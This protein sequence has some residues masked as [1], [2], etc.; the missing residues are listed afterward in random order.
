ML[1]I[2]R[3]ILPASLAQEINLEYPHSSHD[4]QGKF[5]SLA[6]TGSENGTWIARPGERGGTGFRERTRTFGGTLEFDEEFLHPVVHHLHLVIAHH[7]AS[8]PKKAHGKTGS[9]REPIDQENRNKK[10]RKRFAQDPH[11][12]IRSISR[13]LLGDDI[14]DRNQE[15][16]R[17]RPLLSRGSE[18][19]GL[20]IRV[21]K[22]LR[23][24]AVRAGVVLAS[25][26][27]LLETYF[28]AAV[29]RRGTEQRGR[30]WNGKGKGTRRSNR[31]REGDRVDASR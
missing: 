3:A 7:P 24:P 30:G 19:L 27:R 5:L 21:R 22:G 1:Y 26:P 29:S 2:N 11:S 15:E 9:T 13:R 28:I 17:P 14:L 12:F 10:A 8:K 4:Q 18:F 16:H 6:Q 23:S 20:R 25:L 31:N